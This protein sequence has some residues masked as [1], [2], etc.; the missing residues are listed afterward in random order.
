MRRLLRRSVPRRAAARALAAG[1]AAPALWRR[2]A[3]RQLAYGTLAGALLISPGAVAGALLMSQGTPIPHPE[4]RPVQPLA[5]STHAA[6][7]SHGVT[8]TAAPFH[9]IILPDVVVIEPK[10]LSPAQVTQIG[11]LTGVR[12]VLAVDGARISAA[13]KPV[14]VLGV[15]PQQFRSWT[16]LRTASDSRLW[17]ALDSQE[18]VASQSLRRQLR[19]HPGT[20]YRLSGAAVRDM[21]FGGSGQFG[22]AGIDVVVSNQ[23]SAGLGLVHNVAALVSAPGVSITTL[24]R[25]VQAVAGPGG[26]VTNVRPQQLPVDQVAAGVRPTTYLGLFKVSA[27][28]FCPGMSW[29]V[30]AAIGQIESGDGANV[31]PS[32]AGALG[33][34]QFI[35]STWATWG[36]S[37]FGEPGPPNVMDPYDAVP[38]AAR[39]LCAAGAGTPS[40]LYSAIFAYNH[41]D[42]YVREVLALAH[43]Y[44]LQYG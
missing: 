31:G 29:T 42:W 9:Q 21:A 7:G 23:A 36:I 13:G 33:P 18:F 3:S 30:L 24:M 16:P 6:S 39:Y 25:E 28:R 34:M 41:A 35:P 32:S 14:N 43:Q 22:V 44:A 12:S 19:L 1:T 40:G 37:A 4:G 2:L 26:K 38:S 11:K 15:D 5:T 8:Q 20:R 10:G 17:S 27:A